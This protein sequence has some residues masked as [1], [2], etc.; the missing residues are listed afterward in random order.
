M[1]Q[2]FA[3]SS[4]VF[5][6]LENIVDK[7]IIVENKAIDLISA[8]VIRNLEYFLIALI[9]GFTGVFGPL[10]FLFSWPIL[11]VGVLGMFSGIFYTYVLTKLEVTGYSAVTYV[12]PVIFLLIDVF[13]LKSAITVVQIFGIILL[14]LGGL[15][16]VINPKTLRIK[17][18]YT[19]YI[20]MIFLFDLIYGGVEYYIFKHY[21][22]SQ[23]LN[24][25][26]FVVS[27]WLMAMITYFAIVAWQNRWHKLIITALK[28]KYYAK[29][30]ISKTFDVLG[31]L[32]SF[33]AIK[34]SLVSKAT[35][36]DS[37]YPL[38]LLILIFGAQRMFK[39]NAEEDFHSTSL[40]QKIFA[41]V[42]LVL[43]AWLSS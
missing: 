11:L 23:D 12:T 17:P 31:A 28:N 5:S 10:H 22:G 29:V 37:F 14:V 41:T 38:I 8:S 2:L 4:I 25:I 39:F 19:K 20:W 6:A 9:V 16:F 27:T 21:S 30:S 13:I 24:E 34:L 40:K 33:H 42:L 36:F 32:A 1:W 35:A 15:F 7:I 26:S 18:E 3:F 43:G